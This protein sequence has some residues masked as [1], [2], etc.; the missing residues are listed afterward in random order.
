MEKLK[1]AR[2]DGPEVRVDAEAANHN[3]KPVEP[4]LRGDW[5]NLCLLTLLYIM[6]SI[7]IGLSMAIPILLESNKNITYDDQVKL[8]STRVRGVNDTSGRLSVHCLVSF[9]GRVQFLRVFL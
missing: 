8:Q 1:I 9:S 6:Q 4:N 2:G 5:S 3:P 7:P